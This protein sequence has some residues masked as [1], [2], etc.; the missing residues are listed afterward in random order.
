MAY[1][2][3][4]KNREYN[5]EYYRNNPEFQKRQIERQKKRW[6]N[7]PEHRARVNELRATPKYRERARRTQNERYKNDPEYRAQMREDGKRR[8]AER[9]ALAESV[10]GPRVC[11]QCQSTKKIHAH[12]VDSTTK[13][14][15]LS[16][17]PKRKVEEFMAEV[18]K[19][20]WLC[21]TCHITLHS[22]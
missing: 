19:C 5:R 14:F 22:T 4:E 1:P 21:R 16:D 17:G 8:R 10:I 6:A 13:C 7:D 12:H 3:P 15:D 18:R 9:W 11:S 20:V 2:D